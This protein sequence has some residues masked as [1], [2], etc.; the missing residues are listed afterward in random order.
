MPK[1]HKPPTENPKPGI[2]SKPKP[3]TEAMMN[4]AFANF[5]EKYQPSRS[6]VSWTPEP[7]RR[8]KILVD[9]LVPQA[10][11][12]RKVLHPP[13]GPLRDEFL[14]NLNTALH[15][16]RD[17][18]PPPFHCR[19]FS[20]LQELFNRINHNEEC[21]FNPASLTALLKQI[22]PLIHEMP[23]V[24]GTA[25]FPNIVTDPNVPPGEM[26]AIP[27]QF[28]SRAPGQTYPYTMEELPF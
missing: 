17:T 4:K 2:C 22:S 26:Y 6:A 20:L 13:K 5:A 19:L 28:T 3:L 11:K 9:G 18:I 16:L 10:T 25:M 14:R 24:N 8:Y 1:K 21:C 15:R 12:P 23:R 27:K 7:Y